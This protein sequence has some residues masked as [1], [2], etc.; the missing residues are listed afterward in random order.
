MRLYCAAV[1]LVL[2]RSFEHIGHD[3]NIVA[4]PRGGGAGWEVDHNCFD[5]SKVAMRKDAL[6]EIRASHRHGSGLLLS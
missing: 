2:D 4:V 1:E 5:F 6:E 3:G